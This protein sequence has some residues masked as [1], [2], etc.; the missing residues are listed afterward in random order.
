MATIFY[1]VMGEGRGHAARAYSMTE[2]LRSR[3]RIFLYS[4]HDAL[5]FL[6]DKYADASDVVVREIPGVKFHYADNRLALTKTIGEGLKFWWN[7]RRLAKPI[8]DDIEREQPSL[9]ASDFEPLVARA[10]H[11][12]GLPVLSLDHQHFLVAYDLSGLPVRHRWRARS[13]RLAVWMFNIAE[14]K[15]VVSAFYRPPLRPGYE[16]MT[17]VGPLLRPA[18]R[19]RKPTRGD[20]LLCYFRRQTPE[21]VVKMIAGLPIATRIYGLGQR[22]SLENAEFFAVDELSFTEALVHCQGV[23]AAAGNQLLGEALYLEKPFFALPEG[24]HFEQCINAHF[25]KQLGGGEWAPLEEVRLSH[26]DKFLANMPAYHQNLQ[27]RQE[28]F[29]GTTAAAEAIEAMLPG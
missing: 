10:A 7:R 12:A 15:S 21:S 29:D 18:I 27:G 17:Q 28:E 14:H 13:M 25:L 26:L 19:G 4:S 2:A 20:Y 11:R 9:V 22:P 8:L 6:R 23:I 16:H 1:G 5:E 3:H 24:K